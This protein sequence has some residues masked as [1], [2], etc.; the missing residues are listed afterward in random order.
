MVFNGN[1]V[2]KK[3][4]TIKAEGKDKRENNSFLRLL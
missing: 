2:E 1:S 4:P 3:I